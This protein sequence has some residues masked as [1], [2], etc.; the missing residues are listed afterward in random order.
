M[1]TSYIF[2][3]L[4][5]KTPI[6]ALFGKMGWIPFK[7]KRWACMCRTWN[8]YIDMDDSRLNKQIFLY[9]YSSNADTWCTDFHDVC[10]KLD[11]V[12]NFVNLRHID[13]TVFHT[14]LELYARENWS[15][16]VESKPKLRTYKLFKS[17]PNAEHYV[18]S[19]MRRFQRSTFAKFRCG[20]LPIQIELGR[21]RGQKVEDRICPLCT[22]AVESEIHFLLECTFF[23]RDSF[24]LELGINPNLDSVEKLKI[25]M[26]E[27]QKATSKF[28]CDLWKKRQ[29][30]LFGM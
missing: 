28:L 19:Y 12:D 5:P 8:Q 20:I 9:D 26:S 29:K 16:T 6:P 17:E 23:D 1:G 10:I 21:F 3:G 7:F 14:Q 2:L 18:K 22:T 4:H 11:L 27:H 30:Y 24:F 25:C 15:L 13:P